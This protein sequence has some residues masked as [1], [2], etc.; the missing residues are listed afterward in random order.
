MAEN[1]ISNE[2]RSEGKKRDGEIS[3]MR[4]PH[5]PRH[6]STQIG[7]KVAER[8]QNTPNLPPTQE[9]ILQSEAVELSCKLKQNATPPNPVTDVG[10]FILI[11]GLGVLTRGNFRDCLVMPSPLTEQGRSK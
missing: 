5:F 10:A 3:S 2:D 8:S 1:R 11:G 7:K 9:R 6:G 4:L